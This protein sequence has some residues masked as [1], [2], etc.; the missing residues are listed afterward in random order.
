[1]RIVPPRHVKTCV[2]KTDSAT[3]L[4][5]LAILVDGVLIRSIVRQCLACEHERVGRID[6]TTCAPLCILRVA[7]H[8][9]VC[10][11]TD[12]EEAVQTCVDASVKSVTVHLRHL[13]KTVLLV[14]VERNVVVYGLATAL[15]CSVN[16][17]CWSSVV[18]HLV[19]P[20]G[21]D[22]ILVNECANLV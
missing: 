20:V 11:E 18:D 5:H 8:T 1:M 10:C 6:L 9:E 12:L 16:V 13:D 17:E 19:A 15:H 4:D 21:V 3:T 14:V 22:V 7:L 2:L